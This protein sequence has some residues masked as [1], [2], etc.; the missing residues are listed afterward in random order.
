MKQQNATSNQR[1][2]LMLKDLVLIGIFDVIYLVIIMACDCMGI[3][4]IMYLIYPTIAAIIAGPLVLLFMAKE[5][6]AF[7]FLI[8]G[9]IPPALMFLL[10]NTYV[11]LVIVII[12]TLLA[13]VLRKIGN[14][15]SFTWNTLAYAVYSLWI[16]G[17]LSQM[18]FVRER[19]LE[20]CKIMGDD[21]I[22][23]LVNLLTWQNMILVAIGAFV[24]AVIGALIGKKLL[25]KHFLKAGIAA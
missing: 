16:P 19:F 5:Q 24:G 7:A 13:E 10:G 21:Y 4:P 22:A 20:M 17:V 25:K 12:T 8:F 23:V 2:S 9:F 1:S 14:Y 11:V 6:K 3:V 15:S 18:I